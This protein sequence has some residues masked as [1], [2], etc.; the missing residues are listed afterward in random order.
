MLCNMPG[1][2]ICIPHWDVQGKDFRGTFSPQIHTLRFLINTVVLGYDVAFPSGAGHRSPYGPRPS[3]VGCSY[4]CL[5]SIV[6]VLGHTS[7]ARPLVPAVFSL[8]SSLGIFLSSSDVSQLSVM[9]CHCHTQQ[10]E[11][12]PISYCTRL[13]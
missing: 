5:P 4:P 10:N 11:Q 2:F 12:C 7:P 8:P 1:M 9:E 6:S 13:K 3:A